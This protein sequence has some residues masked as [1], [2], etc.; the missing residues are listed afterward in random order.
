M[1][2]I[3]LVLSIGICLTHAITSAQSS[4]PAEKSGKLVEVQVQFCEAKLQKP[5]LEKLHFRV[6]VRNLTAE[7]QWV[8]LPSVLYSAPTRA[9]SGAGIAEIELLQNQSHTIKF[10][11]FSGSLRVVPGRPN[12]GGGFQGLLLG[13]RTGITLPVTI[14]YWGRPDAPLQLSGII[15]HHVIVSGKSVAQYFRTPLANASHGT[16]EHLS[17][18]DSWESPDHT[19]VAVRVERVGQFSIPNALASKCKPEPQ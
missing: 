15:A 14:D 8:L 2:S 18:F 5:P 12:D 7:P 4:S 11:R 19:E 17:V 6:S 10:L 13:S 3:W 1:R 9:P 16:A